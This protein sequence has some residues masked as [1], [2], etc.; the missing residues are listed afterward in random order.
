MTPA[1]YW[2]TASIARA[3]A[4]VRPVPSLMNVVAPRRDEQTEHPFSHLATLRA[5]QGDK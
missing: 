4:N 2:W 1:P 3:E 5:F